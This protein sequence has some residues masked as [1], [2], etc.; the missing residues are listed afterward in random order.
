VIHSNEKINYLEMSPDGKKLV[1]AGNDGNLYIWDVA[2][3]Y[4]QTVYKI[5]NAENTAGR[6]LTAAAFMPDGRRIVVGN[7][8]GLLR[9]VDTGVVVRELSGHTSAIEKIKLNFGGNFM[10]TASKDFSVRLW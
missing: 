10:A 2:N 8:R 3:N 9:I 4:S 1:G 5:E 6:G 7:V